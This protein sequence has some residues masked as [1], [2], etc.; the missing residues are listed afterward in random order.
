MKQFTYEYLGTKFKFN[1]LQVEGRT[2]SPTNV[3]LQNLNPTTYEWKD[4]LSHSRV[5]WYKIYVLL[6]TS[7]TSNQA[8]NMCLG[9]K[10]RS[11]NLRVEGRTMSLIS[12]LVKILSL[13]TYEWMDEPSRSRVPWSKF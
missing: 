6:P 9:T 11:Y 1:Y 2:K 12:S 5:P 13:P 8:T 3:L 4:E 10:F 7:G